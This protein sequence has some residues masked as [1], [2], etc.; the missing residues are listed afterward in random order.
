MSITIDFKNVKRLFDRDGYFISK[1]PLFSKTKFSNL[2]N[3][4]EEYAQ[5][6]ANKRKD[7]L[8]TPHF[9]EN[10]MFDYLLDESVLDIIEQF[11]GPNIGIWSSHFICKDAV[12]GRETPWHEDS[13]LWQDRLRPMKN[14][15]TIWLALD[16][17]NLENGCMQVVPG[18]HKLPFAKYEKVQGKTFAS[19]IISSNEF[20]CKAVPV[21]LKPN[22]YSI[23]DAKLI[24]GAE[25]N[26]SNERR[27]GLT[28]RYFSLESYF[29]PNHPANQ[30]FKVYFARGNNIAK[31]NLEYV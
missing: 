28:M 17:V 10:R 11:I 23:H 1:K 16:E 25:A 31:S 29:D 26:K 22:E 27:C 21:C 8:D 4:F 3:L 9:D 18:T 6:H 12:D 30:N 5:K 7:Q 13:Y 2:Q 24:H 20:V 14:V 19:Q 15:L